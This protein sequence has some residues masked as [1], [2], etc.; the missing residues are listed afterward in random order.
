MDF[1]LRTFEKPLIAILPVA[2]IF[3]ASLVFWLLVFSK[4]SL[5]R[6]FADQGEPEA[7]EKEISKASLT[8]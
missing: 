7:K 4:P 6:R 1:V 5:W 2:I 3:T 8:G